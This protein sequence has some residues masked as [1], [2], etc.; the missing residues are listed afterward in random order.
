MQCYGYQIESA[1]GDEQW[2]VLARNDEE[3]IERLPPKDKPYKITYK[4]DDAAECEGPLA[5][6]FH[7][8][9][10]GY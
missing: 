7:T 3:A 2:L 5:T 4:S 10:G 9:R 8:Y 6:R 1:T